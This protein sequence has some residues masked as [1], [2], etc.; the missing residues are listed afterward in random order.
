MANLDT[1]FVDTWLVARATMRRK[2]VLL[3]PVLAYARSIARCASSQADCAASVAREDADDEVA[4]PSWSHAICASCFR[5]RYPLA[6]LAFQFGK[7]RCVHCLLRAVHVEGASH[8]KSQPPHLFRVLPLPLLRSHLC[9]T[10]RGTQHP[11]V[12]R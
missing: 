9:I 3:M 4:R 6:R 11:L 7:L 8:S 2:S 10:K 1:V 5:T 12:M